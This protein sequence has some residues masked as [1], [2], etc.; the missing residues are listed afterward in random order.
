MTGWADPYASGDIPTPLASARPNTTVTTPA[1]T[2]TAATA[3]PASSTGLLSQA[4]SGI[5]S[6]GKIQTWFANLV[7]GNESANSFLNLEDVIFILVG[8]LLVGA[9]LF[10]FKGTQTV[11]QQVS[12]TASRAA[13]VAA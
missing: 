2:P 3:S 10:S 1:T 6:L 9:A 4:L 8:L 7:T 5:S 11:I 12:K 13:E